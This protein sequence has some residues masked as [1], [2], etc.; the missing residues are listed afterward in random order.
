MEI[1]NKNEIGL[2]GVKEVIAS[3]SGKYIYSFMT[4]RQLSEGGF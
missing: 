3:I 4:D 1:I 2:G